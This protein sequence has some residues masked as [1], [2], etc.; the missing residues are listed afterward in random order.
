MT[1]AR[2]QRSHERM[3]RIEQLVQYFE[4]HPDSAARTN[5][6]ELVGLLLEVHGDCLERLVEIVLEGNES[7]PALLHD[8][9]DEQTISSVLL[10]HGLH[11]VD[12]ETRVKRALDSVRPVL[13][14]HGGSIELRSIGTDR[15]IR[16]ALTGSCDG[17][18]SSQQTL[19]S[20]IED[21]IYMAAPETA[22]I[23]LEST[24]A[25]A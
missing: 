25:S 14:R 15:T 6:R 18:S 17:C 2:P 12:F 23:E 16:L 3:G 24:G 10:L 8:L 1:P 21:A 20:T 22:G 4:T 5:A 7:G 13:A 11:P 19:A 9:E